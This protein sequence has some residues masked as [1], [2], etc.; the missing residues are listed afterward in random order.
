VILYLSIHF[1]A[2]TGISPLNPYIDSPKGNNMP[3]IAPTEP[4]IT[5]IQFMNRDDV[6]TPEYELKNLPS[7]LFN[8]KDYI[9]YRLNR[10]RALEPKE[11]DVVNSILSPVIEHRINCA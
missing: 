8:T 5:T 10:E 4:A 11:K 3:H 7:E 2:L 6:F 1:V 9:G